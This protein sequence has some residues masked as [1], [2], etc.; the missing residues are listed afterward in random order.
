LNSKAIEILTDEFNKLPGIGRKSAQRLAFY[1]VEMEQKEAQ[2]LAKAIMDVKESVKKCR[3]CGNLTENE[4]CG[5]CDDET[6]DGAVICVVEEAR[7]ILAVERA[8]SF[9]GK[10][11]VLHGKIS[12]LNGISGDDLNLKSL[13]TRVG[14]GEVEEVILALNPDLEGETTSAYITKLLK[15]F[16]VKVTKLASGIPIGGNIE[17]ADVATIARAIEGRRESE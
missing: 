10:Y 7:D 2:K 12:P 16:D 8:R 14:E 1:V 4:I 13:I 9:K 3:I 5:I 6:R 15:N 11:H 17:F